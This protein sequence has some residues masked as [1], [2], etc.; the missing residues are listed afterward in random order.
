MIDLSVRGIACSGPAPLP[1]GRHGATGI[2]SVEGNPIS[3]GGYGINYGV[4]CLEYIPGSDE[5]VSIDPLLSHRDYT[6]AAK[7]SGLFR[8]W[9]AGGFYNP[10]TSE[11]YGDSQSLSVVIPSEGTTD[12]P[13]AVTID[14]YT[15]LYIGR[16]SYIINPADETIE[17]T[18]TQLFY[19]AVGSACGLA[20]KSN[21]QKMVLVAGG[22]KGS[23]NGNTDEVQIF[24]VE[25]QAWRMGE[26]VLPGGV[27]E[28]SAAVQWGRTFLLTGGQAS[29]D[30]STVKS[31]L[32]LEFSP[33]DETWIVREE[34]LAKPRSSHIAV[35]VNEE[36]Y[37]ESGLC[38]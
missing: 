26:N 14:D 9:F 33:D 24:D 13:C 27:L 28:Y 16:K 29:V 5:W 19:P 7:L 12:K 17:E 36:P 11:I 21:G 31:D 34:R 18:P 32:I 37:V 20:R 1:E 25:A 15:V 3:C 2:Q 8:Y 10:D 38:Q 22:Y 4:E 6:P 35:L 23:L 30:T